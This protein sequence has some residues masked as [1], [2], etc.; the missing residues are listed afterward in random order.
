MK[1][2]LFLLVSLFVMNLVAFADNDKPI[3][4]TEMPKAAQQFIKS[5]FA[6][7]SVALAK[8]ETEFLD[9]TYDVIFTNGD[10]VEFDKKGKWIKVDCKHTQVP[11]EIV[12]VAIQQYVAK[13]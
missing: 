11:S 10:Q 5:Y 9:K 8:I 7:K 4:V 6:N 2:T 12:P 3:Q 1:K 13:N